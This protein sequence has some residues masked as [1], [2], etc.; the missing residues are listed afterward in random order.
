MDVLNFDVLNSVLLQTLTVFGVHG[1]GDGLFHSEESPQTIF[2]HR[3]LLPLRKVIEAWA[4]P[5]G[6]MGAENGRPRK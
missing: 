3:G 1:I 2:S 4:D 6:R 5:A